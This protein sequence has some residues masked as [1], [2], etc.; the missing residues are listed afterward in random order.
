MS[1]HLCERF[2]PTVPSP[3]CVR[4][5]R[6]AHNV[7][8]TYRFKRTHL[9]RWREIGRGMTALVASFRKA[10]ASQSQTRP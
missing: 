7:V 2:S 6:V 8:L 9:T 4:D 10:P 1:Q 3:N 5:M